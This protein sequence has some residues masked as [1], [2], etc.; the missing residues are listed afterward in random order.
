MKSRL[1]TQ[2]NDI[3]QN[4]LQRLN[5]IYT[6]P[7]SEKGAILA[8]D[9]GDGKTLTWLNFG[10]SIAKSKPKMLIVSELSPINDWITECE[11][12]F[13]P[14]LSTIAVGN[15]MNG[16]CDFRNLYWFLL[17]QY[18]VVIVNYDTLAQSHLYT[19]KR[20]LSLLNEAIGKIDIMHPSSANTASFSESQKADHIKARTRREVLDTFLKEQANKPNLTIPIPDLEISKK[21]KVVSCTEFRLILFYHQWDSVAF[22]EADKA[23]TPGTNFYIACTQLKSNFYCA[24]TGTPF[25]NKLGDLQ[26]MFE[27]THISPEN[28]KTW[29]EFYKNVDEY[30]RVFTERRNEYLILS[31]DSEANNDKYKACQ[32]YIH[33]DFTSPIERVIY[34]HI[35]SMSSHPSQQNNSNMLNG[36]TRLR[37]ACNGIYDKDL[38]ANNPMFEKHICTLNDNKIELVNTI[39][40]KIKMLLACVALIF[41]R[42]EKA[43][44]YTSYKMSI[45]QMTKHLL[46]HYPHLPVYVAT[47]EINTD[48]R[49]KIRQ[50]FSKVPGSALLLTVDIFDTGVNIQAANH[51]IHYDNWWNPVKKSQRTHR[52]AR[53]DQTRSIFIWN[54]IISNSIEESIFAVSHMKNQYSSIALTQTITPTIVNQITSDT[55]LSFVSDNN[56]VPIEL[57]SSSSEPSSSS[58][59]ISEMLGGNTIINILKQISNI[60]IDTLLDPGIF[61]SIPATIPLNP[62]TSLP[63]P[64]IRNQTLPSSSSSSSSSFQQQQIYPSK[65]KKSLKKTPHHLDLTKKSTSLLYTSSLSQQSK[66]QMVLLSSEEIQ[67]FKRP[68]TS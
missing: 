10:L 64:F 56:A 44:V 35:A 68:R 39:P 36:I 53:I 55:A 30:C 42:K 38:F 19:M 31:A 49:T 15:T 1:I 16:L 50:M 7:D 28:G 11:K 17:Q 18:D 22:D 34:D 27:I 61:E 13:S 45:T 23:R 3:Q 14:K 29:Y 40:T 6:N 46:V 25:N 67:V 52:V 57:L 37:Q 51:V 59:K 63:Q 8:L 26:S 21:E 33:C 32:I 20:R 62:F 60:Y 65:E 9:P 47:G 41:S 66:K 2:L 58:S 12:H 24:I 5:H 43:I 48:E 4:A 54:F